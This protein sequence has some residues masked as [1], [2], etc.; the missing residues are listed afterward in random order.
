MAFDHVIEVLLYLLLYFLW[1]AI[2][3]REV[4]LKTIGDI[5]VDAIWWAVKLLF[6]FKSTKSTEEVVGVE[7][8]GYCLNPYIKGIASIAAANY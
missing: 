6:V 1:Y 2:S 3:Y 7:T 4:L 5:N 8:W